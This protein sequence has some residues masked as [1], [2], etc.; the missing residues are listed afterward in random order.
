MI[1]NDMK[2]TNA[3]IEE[4]PHSVLNE[5]LESHMP[6]LKDFSS[7][8]LALTFSSGPPQRPTAKSY[9]FYFFRGELDAERQPDDILTFKVKLDDPSKIHMVD[10]YLGGFAFGAENAPPLALRDRWKP[11]MMVIE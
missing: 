4:P 3:T 6:N 9:V 7:V 1:L 11:G 10:K 2:S 5:P 8:A